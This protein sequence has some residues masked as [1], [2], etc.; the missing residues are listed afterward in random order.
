MF[1]RANKH[2]ANAERHEAWDGKGEARQPLV[3]LGY[4]KP[5]LCYT[6]GALGCA[7]SHITLWQR[8][9]REKTPLM[10]FE[11]DAIAHS[12]LET[13]SQELVSEHAP[14]DWDMITWGWN[15]DCPIQLDLIP[16]VTQSRV[17]LNQQDLAR[18]AG[19]YQKTLLRPTLYPMQ[20]CFG[21]P[22]YSISPSGAEQLLKEIF[23]LRNFTMH[24]DLGDTHNTALD[25]AL[26]TM[27]SRLRSYACFPP[28]VITP[29]DK[30]ISTITSAPAKD[31]A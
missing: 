28:L 31:A 25:V 9:V 13:L 16:G 12:D 4:I 5:D 14:Y 30:S 7:L 6:D 18:N 22:C 2:L 15:F 10:I 19:V 8:V 27:H 26:N 29:N 3:D 21:T 24:I 20:W 11:D 17:L 1:Q 23:P